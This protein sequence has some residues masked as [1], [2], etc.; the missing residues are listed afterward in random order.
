MDTVETV[1]AHS[2]P[3]GLVNQL[4]CDGAECHTACG[5]SRS[6]CSNLEAGD[7]AIGD[8][9]ADRLYHCVAGRAYVDPNRGVKIVR[10]EEAAR[11]V[12]QQDTGCVLEMG[13]GHGYKLS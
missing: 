6:G 7:H 2:R 8:G 5:S 13:T 4:R 1:H 12:R 11:T 3:G 9:S 10:G